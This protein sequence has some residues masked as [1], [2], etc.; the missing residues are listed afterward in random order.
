MSEQAALDEKARRVRS[1]LS[2]YYG[3]T[4]EGDETD[5]GGD[6]SV[7]TSSRAGASGGGVARARASPTSLDSA[8]F[9]V[10]KYMSTLLKGTR[11]DGLL[12]KHAEMST[13][14][15]R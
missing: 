4:A 7:G 14:I 1:L 5:A 12:G 15:K 8:A 9:D 6:A 13:E 3:N 10:T 11:I 2:S